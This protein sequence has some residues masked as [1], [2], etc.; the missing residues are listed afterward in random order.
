VS[1]LEFRVLTTDAE[2][3][4]FL[5]CFKNFVKVKLPESYSRNGSV[6]GVFK[7]NEMIG[8]YM[9]ITKGPF[10][11][12][13]FVPDEVKKNLRLLHDVNG[14]DFVEVNGFWVHEKYRRSRESLQMWLQLRKDVLATKASHL[15]LFYNSQ[16]KGLAQIYE[17]VMN[18]RV[19]YQGAPFANSVATTSH[20]EVTISLVS[21]LDVR[22]SIY[23]GLGR[24]ITR[25]VQTNAA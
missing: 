9:L 3:D 5:E 10:R 2:I 11:S 14:T 15:L 19:I 1:N 25:T 7:K 6:I 18:P 23:R 17:S 22:L 12:L 4:H 20:Q 21:R 13:A 24:I 16:A 8:G